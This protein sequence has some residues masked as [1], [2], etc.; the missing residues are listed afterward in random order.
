MFCNKLSIFLVIF[1]TLYPCFFL[2]TLK[3]LFPIYNFIVERITRNTS[4]NGKD[5]KNYFKTI[6]LDLKSE[7]HCNSYPKYIVCNMLLHQLSLDKYKA[8]SLGLN[9]HISPKADPV[10]I[11]T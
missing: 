5:L 10:L 9:H 4:I 6:C 2:I 1:N 3:I 8:L 7:V 11:C